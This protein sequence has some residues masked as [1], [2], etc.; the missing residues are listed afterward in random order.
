MYMQH[1]SFVEHEV[2]GMLYQ[3]QLDF[4]ANYHL[5]ESARSA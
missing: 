2:L 3:M 5:P 1:I 4:Q